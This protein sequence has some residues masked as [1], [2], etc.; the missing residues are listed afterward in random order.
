MT[1]ADH[2]HMVIMAG[3]SGER[4]WPLSRNQT[5]KQLLRLFSDETLLGETVKRVV[6]LVPADHLSILTHQTQVDATRKALPHF[7]PAQ[8]IGEPAKRD[9]APAAA[10]ASALAYREHP[11]AVVVL[12]PADQL[13]RDTEAFRL[14]ISDCVTRAQSSDALIT[15]AI[16]PTFPSTGYGYLDL[17]GE[18]ACGSHGT[19]FHPVTRF[20]EKPDTETAQTYLKSGHHFWN[21]GMFIWKASTFHSCS[22]TLVPKL[23]RFIMEFPRGDFNAYLTEHFPTLPKISVD[24]AIMEKAPLV[25]AA[26]ATFDWNDVGAWTALPWVLPADEQGNTIK[27]SVSIHSSES[28]IVYAQSRHVALCGV[29]DLVVVETPDAVL[30]CHREQVQEIKKLLPNLPDNLR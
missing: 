27:G 8:I 22:E 18:V 12:L 25:E 24:Y 29:A 20:V 30:V 3:G 16:P 21:A 13:I 2:T 5:P 4:F 14:Q 11:D 10:L 1:L 7:P 19:R 26:L 28:N 6:D 23:S 17:G 15:L 9:T